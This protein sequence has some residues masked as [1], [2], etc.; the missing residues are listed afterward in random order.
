MSFPITIPVF[1]ALLRAGLPVI[2]ADD[3]ERGIV[4]FGESIYAEKRG[5]FGY[6]NGKPGE[7][8]RL[9]LRDPIIRDA[10][11]RAIWRKLRPGDPEPLNSP[12]FRRDAF[13]V[14][15]VWDIEKNTGALLAVAF[16]PNGTSSPWRFVVPALADITD[17]ADVAG[18]DIDCDLLALGCVC[19]AV[20]S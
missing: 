7:S 10:C 1:A 2:D 5:P 16:A 15:S 3:G 17:I 13:N 19:V 14:W 4:M 12:K 6:I 8:W 18:D 9:D 20:L 11:V